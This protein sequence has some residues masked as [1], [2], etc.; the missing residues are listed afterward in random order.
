[1][2]LS[3]RYQTALN[4]VFEKHWGAERRH[5]GVPYLAHVL[6][7]SSLV[8]EYGGDEDTAVA[9]LLHDVVEDAGGE[10]VIPELRRK[11]GE[12]IAEYVLACSDRITSELPP[13]RER[14]RAFLERVAQSG[15]PVQLIVLCDKLHNLRSLLIVYRELGETMWQSYRGGREGSLWYYA[16][17]HRLICPPAIPQ[18]LH[19]EFAL[20]LHRLLTQ[21]GTTLEQAL[22]FIP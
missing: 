13:W 22:S 10:A 20:T 8:L 17:I 2:Q 5:R 21:A 6:A 16:Q 12:R 15:P 3:E 18:D 9:A 4:Y 19:E 11:F 7:V 14:K 1:M